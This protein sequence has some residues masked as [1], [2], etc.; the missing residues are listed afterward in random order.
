MILLDTHIWLW[1]LADDPSLT[2]KIIESIDGADGLL[3]SAITCWEIT[4]KAGAGKLELGLPP[5]EWIDRALSAP[6]ISVAPISADI[7]VEAALL[8][9]E[10]HKDP[11]DRIIVATARVMDCQLLTVDSKIIGYEHVKLA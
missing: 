3:V 7:A 2:P 1:W 8:P 5:R 9:G 11:A 6:G 4:Q 10:F